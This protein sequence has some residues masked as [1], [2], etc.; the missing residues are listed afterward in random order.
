MRG[1]IFK[2]H[3]KILK[4]EFVSSNVDVAVTEKQF[5]HN[6]GCLGWCRSS[7]CASNFDH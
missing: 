4:N 7:L 6:K 5:E 1:Y 2:M 3:Y